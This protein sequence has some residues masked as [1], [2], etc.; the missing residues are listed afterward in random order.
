MPNDTDIIQGIQQEEAIIIEGEPSAASIKAKP[1]RYRPQAGNANFFQQ[2][3][4]QN[5]ETSSNRSSNVPEHEANENV[6]DIFG[7]FHLLRVQ[8]IVI[9]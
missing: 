2:L 6:E 8:K 7:H 1:K 3:P 5:A 9:V 4:K